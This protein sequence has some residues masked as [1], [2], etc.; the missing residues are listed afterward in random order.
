MTDKVKRPIG[1]PDKFTPERRQAILDDISHRIPYEFAAEANG[2]C[3]DTL[4]EWL[5]RGFIDKKIGIESEYAIFSEDLKKIERNK[6][7]EHLECINSNPERWQAQ[8]WILERRWWKQFSPNAAVLDFNKRLDR[9]E[10]EE[11]EKDVKALR[12]KAKEITEK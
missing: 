6:I 2:I 12:G 10:A 4:Y 1:R 7:R 3:E 11:G 5:K 8:A 9:M